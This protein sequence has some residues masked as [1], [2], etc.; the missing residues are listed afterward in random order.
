[1]IKKSMC[2]LLAAVVLMAT[3]CASILSKSGY[4]ISINSSPSE[5]KITILDRKGIEIYKG[6]TPATLKL[7]SGAGFFKRARY[8][9]VFSKAGF[10][11]KTVPVYFKM[12]GWYWGNLLI[13]GVVG[14]LIVDPATGAMYKLDTEFLNE[15]LTRSTANIETEELRVYQIND[16]PA[17][18]ADH[19]VEIAK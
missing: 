3:G 9:V 6:N 18:W 11:T 2:L 7:K 8:Q 14:M 1:M 10:D 13:G 4:P 17:G 16:I 15:T 5:A 12:D 19:L